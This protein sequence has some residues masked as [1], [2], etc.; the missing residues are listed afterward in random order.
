MT[1]RFHSLAPLELVGML[2]CST[3]KC[4]QAALGAAAAS[5]PMVGAAAA[6]RRFN[7]S[8]PP[9]SAK[10]QMPK[11]GTKKRQ[12]AP[13]EP[14]SYSAVGANPYNNFDRVKHWHMLLMCLGCAAGGVAA[15]RLIDMDEE[16]V[17]KQLLP[18]FNQEEIEASLQK[19]FEFRPDL[20]A[21]ILRYAFVHAA[22]R[23][24]RSG[25]LPPGCPA[26]APVGP[27]TGFDACSSLRGVEEASRVIDSIR[28][29][30]PESSKADIVAVAA[31]AAVR[32]LNGPADKI[33]FRWG[34]TDAGDVEPTK[35]ALAK[36]ID[37]PAPR[38]THISSSG[39]D[40]IRIIDPLV[41]IVPNL[42]LEEAFAL[43][44]SHAVGEFHEEVSGVPGG[45]SYAR[46]SRHKFFLGVHYFQILVDLAEELKEANLPPRPKDKPDQPTP[47]AMLQATAEMAHPT[48]RKTI[49]RTGLV[50][51]DEVE[52]LVRD[53]EGL[54]V[55]TS[56]ASDNE[57]WK[58]NYARGIA[59]LF[60]AGYDNL[61]W[62]V[63]PQMRAVDR[64][65]KQRAVED[66][67][68][69]ALQRERFQTSPT[70][71]RLDIEAEK[72]KGA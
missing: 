63:T 39:N 40:N 8:E 22:E 20:A 26:T 17:R 71:S 10:R 54:E 46:I 5:S 7:M 67:P 32:F 15:G 70:K 55:V 3:A 9:A 6:S 2:R 33:A 50:T 37:K 16:Q 27:T 4:V 52:S 36:I 57:L 68:V 59:K 65:A 23:A 64:E 31:I 61:R 14:H 44:A 30:Y 13:A 11:P 18:P 25:D 34:R 29:S 62:Y 48:T 49:K 66:T 41:K 24:R 56:L 19:D 35:S 12:P 42:N 69:P 45:K 38:D 21:T 47:P 28:D 53:L 43:M 60:D 72:K 51:R 1:H 58:E